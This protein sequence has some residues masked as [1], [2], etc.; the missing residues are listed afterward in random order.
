MTAEDKELIKNLR[1]ERDRL[2]LLA[3]RKR[4]QV[5]ELMEPDGVLVSPEKAHLA[6][7]I[8]AILDGF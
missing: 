1:A 8:R 2:I 5:V 6:T 4:D 7:Q 3:R